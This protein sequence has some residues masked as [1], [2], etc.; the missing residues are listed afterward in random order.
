MRKVEILLGIITFIALTLN[1]FNIPYGEGLTVLSLLLVSM[2]YFAFGF[3]LFNKVGLRDL[4]KKDAFK[5]I[6]QNRIIGAVLIGL[7]LSTAVIGILFKIQSWPGSSFNLGLGLFG[8][9]IGSIV[10]LI[11]YQKTNSPYYTSIFKRVGFYGSIAFVLMLIPNITWLEF[12][13]REHPEYIEAVKRAWDDP[14]N[15]ELWDKVDEE[16]QKINEQE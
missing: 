7:S 4:A 2:L 15:Q 10:G 11:K 9:L 6:S 8:L 12:R 3:A 13:E 1:L 5:G 14:E 16:R